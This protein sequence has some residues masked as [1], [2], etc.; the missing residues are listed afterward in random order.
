MNR[1]LF[2]RNDFLCKQVGYGNFCRRNQ[3]EVLLRYIEHI[4]FKLRKL[5]G[6]CHCGTVNHE[7]RKNF[8]VV[9]VESVKVEHEAHNCS[10]KSRSETFIYSESCAGNLCGS[11]PVKDVKVCTDIPVCLRLEIKLCRLFEFSHFDIRAVIFA[12]LYE[13]SRDVRNVEQSIFDVRVEL[14]YFCVKN[15]NF[16][17]KFLHFRHDCGCIFACLFHLRNFLGNR[18]LFVLHCLNFS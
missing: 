1:K 15:F 8:R 2:F 18:V 14:R 7:R 3:E 11:F 6:S 16:F 10:F 13:I 5:T 4:L 12:N 17:G 9:L